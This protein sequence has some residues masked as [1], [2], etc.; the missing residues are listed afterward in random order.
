MGHVKD[1][2][3][4]KDGRPTTRHGKGLRYQGW[5]T[6]DGQERRG[7]SF[8]K[9]SDAEKKL[10]ELESSVQRGAWV[11]PTDTTTVAEW[12]LIH[13]ATLGHSARTATRLD[14]FIR[15]HVEGTH[16]GGRRLNKVRPSEAQAWATDQGKL[17]SP[18]TLT[19]LVGAVRTAFM[20]A[21]ADHLMAT[22][23]FEAV[24]LPAVED[25]KIVPLTS[26]QVAAI[27]DNIGLRYRAIVIAQAGLG[28]R[29]GEVLALRLQDVD[30]MRR[31]V[32]VENQID[33]DTSE[34]IPP[35]TSRSRRS[36]PLLNAVATELSAHIARCAPS[37]LPRWEGL[38]FHT[39]VGTPF[40]RQDYRTRAFTGAVRKA[41][42]NDLAFPVGTTPHD[43][44]RYSASVLLD[45]GESVV[46]VAELLGHR[47]AALVVRT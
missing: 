9:K 45:A 44:R 47:N 23:P 30:F 31:T 8:P 17:S 10:I 43:L 33:Q 39:S 15:L 42:K 1:R 35:K 20:A 40:L 14:G 34:L 36:I 46:T 7:G 18:S 28:L 2:W 25:V 37:D 22:D 38:L 21:R 3:K 29:I 13:A 41:A 12:M 5:L 16:F 19:R 32:R 6:V 4:T 24:A 27:A 26:D 11:D